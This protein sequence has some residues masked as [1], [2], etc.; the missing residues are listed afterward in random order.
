MSVKFC[1]G[2]L[3][4][5]PGALEALRAAGQGPGEFLRRHL[6]GDWG[7]LDEEDKALNDEA[8]ID[9][10]RL[11]SAYETAKGVRLY[12]ITEGTDDSGNRPATTI[13][14]VEEY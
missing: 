7:D 9:G 6:T 8:V 1:P 13:L 10:S 11:L 4:A 12:V 2:Q 3:V 5:T 14:R